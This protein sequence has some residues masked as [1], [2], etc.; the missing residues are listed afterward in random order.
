MGYQAL[1]FSPDEKLA[2][3][4]SQVF[5]ELDFTVEPAHEPFGAVK[6]LM[7]QQLRR[8]RRGLRER[9]ERCPTLQERKKFQLSIKARWR[10]LWSKDSGRGQGLPHRRQPGAHQ[11]DQRRAGQ[12][13]ASG[14]A[15]TFAEELRSAGAEALPASQIRA[16]PAKQRPVTRRLHSSR[17]AETRR[18]STPPQSRPELPEFEAPPATIPETLP[19]RIPPGFSAGLSAKASSAQVQ[20]KPAVPAPATQIRITMADEPAAQARRP[21]PRDIPE[22][23]CPEQLSAGTNQQKSPPR[24]NPPKTR[25]RSRALGSGAAPARAKEVDSTSKRKRN[26]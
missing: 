26:S 14:G 16:M 15:R 7:A 24:R 9:A 22:P 25:P 1:L 10:S 23:L 6:K 18:A 3:I 12:G 21:F 5:T 4:V 17:R 19:H 13:N 2:R 11:A 8:H 20:D